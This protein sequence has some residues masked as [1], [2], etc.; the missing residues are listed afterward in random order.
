VQHFKPKHQHQ[1]GA[2]E[3]GAPEGRVGA[4]GARS[5]LVCGG[6]RSSRLVRKLVARVL[7][8]SSADGQS[9]KSADGRLNL[10]FVQRRILASSS[11]CRARSSAMIACRCSRRIVAHRSF[12]SNAG[13]GAWPT[14]CRGFCF[15]GP[16]V[17]V[18][19]ER[20][21]MA[22]CKC[23]GGA[24]TTPCRSKPQASDRHGI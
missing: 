24:R 14:R 1:A 8:H 17:E 9:V 7:A 22:I 20:D 11:C 4:S 13:P 12:P 23:Q 6:G 15:V 10:S 2:R 3:F 5:F 19:L 18:S 16:T 21:K